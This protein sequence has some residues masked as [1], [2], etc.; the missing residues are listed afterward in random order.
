[1]N[2]QPERLVTVPAGYYPAALIA[3]CAQCRVKVNEL[4][5]WAIKPDLVTL[6]LPTGQKVSLGVYGSWS[7]PRVTERK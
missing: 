6:I 1:M 3:A 4:L 7:L 5:G 2:R